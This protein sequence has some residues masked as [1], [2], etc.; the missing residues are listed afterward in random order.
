ME[1]AGGALIVPRPVVVE[2]GG[3]D[4]RIPATPAADWMLILLEK[5]WADVVPGM[6]EG[7][8]GELYDL[9]TSGQITTADCEAAA[10][11][12]VSAAAGCD[13]WV[14]VK[15]LHAAAADPAA[16][17]ELRSGGLDLLTAPLGAALVALYR[18]Y[19]K[20]SD[21]KDV[22]KLNHELNKLPE[23]VS[24]VDVRYD[25]TAAAAAFEAQFAQRGGR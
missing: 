19:T 8:M 1:V 21:P 7:D 15:L 16:F 3:V 9:I 2:L 23:G 13:W 12:A 22:G 14:A 4:Y 25:E 24:A 5:D 20:D 6:C 10:K 18:I 17:G 11:D